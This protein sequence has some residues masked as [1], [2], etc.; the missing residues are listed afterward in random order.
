M[1][2]CP[3]RIGLDPARA[4]PPAHDRKS[5]TRLAELARFVALGYDYLVTTRD[6]VAATNFE[7]W[8]IPA[9]K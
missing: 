9:P 6:A 4:D 1:K 5:S 2:R 8:T 7:A 3:H